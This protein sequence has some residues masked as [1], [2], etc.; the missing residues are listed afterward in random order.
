MSYTHELR[1]KRAAYVFKVY[2][3]VKQYDIPDTQLVNNVFP[4]YGIFISYS[5]FMRIKGMSR[6]GLP[7]LHNPLPT[8]ENNNFYAKEVY[9][10]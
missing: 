6:K 3:H 8:I 1:L 2:E 9:T 7:K 4:K 10:K 5:A